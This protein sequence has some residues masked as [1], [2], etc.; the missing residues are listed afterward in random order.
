MKAFRSVEREV[1]GEIMRTDIFVKIVSESRSE[2]D[3]KRDLEDSFAVFRDMEARFSRFRPESELSILNG[4]SEMRVSSEMAHIIA[5]C[6]VFHDETGGIFDPSILESLESSGYAGSFGTESFGIPSRVGVG[7]HLGFGELTIDSGSSIVRKP[8]ALRIDLG[9]IAKG[10]AVDKVVRML[11]DRGN[12]DFLVDAGGDIYA[13]GSDL[14]NG[15]DFWGIDI[16]K[17]SGEAGR[18]AL[19]TLRDEAVATSGMDRRRWLVEGEERHH[20][21]DPRTGK[22]AAT[23]LVSVTVL[24]KGVS[25]AEVIAKTVCIL[26]RE[27]GLEFA[28]KHHA[29]VFLTM[30]D[31][32]TVYNEYM[33]PHIYDEKG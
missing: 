17:P 8:S 7:S 1:T 10:Y 11:R 19:L 22:S 21:I 9:G 28:T 31:G 5:E 12:T 15:Y 29:A 27:R 13:S 6:V 33:K 3:L 23:D 26:G 18:A 4:S 30:S 24:G 32:K 2:T 25:R 16:A 20:L 14:E